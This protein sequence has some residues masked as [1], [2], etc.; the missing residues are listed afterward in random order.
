MAR[1][2]SESES[3][4]IT[5]DMVYGEY[6]VKMRCKIKCRMGM[7]HPRAGIKERENPTG[8]KQMKWFR[9]GRMDG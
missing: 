3:K 7:G 4:I 8:V 5:V 9:R 2:G 1:C 6:G